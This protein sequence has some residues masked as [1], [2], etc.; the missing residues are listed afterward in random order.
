MCSRYHLCFAALSQGR[1]HAVPS[2]GRAV[3]GA[4]GARLLGSW[5]V[6]VPAPRCIRRRPLSPFHRPG[7]LYAASWRV[8]LLFLAVYGQDYTGF[9]PK[10]QGFQGGKAPHRKALRHCPRV[11]PGQSVL[12][13]KV[14]LRVRQSIRPPP[15]QSQQGELPRFSWKNPVGRVFPLRGLTA[16]SARQLLPPLSTATAPAADRPVPEYAPGPGAAA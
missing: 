14:L 2:H 7:A 10:C 1:P 11:P 16:P 8:L 15:L 13:P 5:A 12:S 3:T 9:G 6:G 4:P